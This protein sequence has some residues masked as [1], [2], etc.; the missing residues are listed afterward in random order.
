MTEFIREDGKTSFKGEEMS[1]R[2]LKPPV[3]IEDIKLK[4]K[5][6]RCDLVLTVLGCHSISRHD[7]EQ[8]FD[9]LDDQWKLSTAA[10]FYWYKNL[11]HTYGS[12]DIV[13][14]LLLS[15][16]TCSEK[17]NDGTKY[18][19]PTSRSDHNQALHALAQWQCV[20]YYAATLN[21]VAGEPFPTTS[22]ALLYSGET[23]MYYVSVSRQQSCQKQNWVD[24]FLAAD[25]PQR[26]LFKEL[27][28]LT[29]KCD[30][31]GCQI[32]GQTGKHTW[33]VVKHSH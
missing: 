24:N 33:T 21:L 3:Y 6:V 2:L 1:P 20:Y 14:A 23:A 18:L 32:R 27:L 7:I 17:I 8:R 31:D 26:K 15:F 4:D 10:T 25:S 28:Y 22:P 29:T 12:F 11:E 30:E 9:T 13:K 16:L 19:K 5:A